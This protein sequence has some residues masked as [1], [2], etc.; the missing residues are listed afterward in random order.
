MKNNVAVLLS[1]YNGSKYIVELLESLSKQLFKD[2]DLIIRDDGSSDSTLNAILD[3][4][5]NNQLNIHIVDS[6]G[7]AGAA[8][9][10]IK[11]L[12]YANDCQQYSYFLFCD[13]DDIWHQDKIEVLVN[14]IK[15]EE[16]NNPDLPILVHS[17][18]SVVNDNGEKIFPSFWKFQHI[19]PDRNTT[20]RLLIQNT[21][22]GCTAAINR[23]L[24]NQIKVDVECMIVHDWWIALV[25]SAIG[26]I[27]P[28]H[29]QL[30]DYRQHEQNVIGARQYGIVSVLSELYKQPQRLFIRLYRLIKNI[31]YQLSALLYVAILKVLSIVL[32]GYYSILKNK[33]KSMAGINEVNIHLKDDSNNGNEVSMN[34]H[35]KQAKQL[36]LFYGDIANKESK[37]ALIDFSS[38]NQKKYFARKIIILRGKFLPN[39]FYRA[40]RLFISV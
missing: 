37:R 9:S 6:E 23:A 21:V 15:A 32:G 27:V 38:I 3:Y 12:D 26:K 24:S 33:V 31:V 40:L 14:T 4:Q 1:T 29:Q 13:Q 22:T 7:N 18:L 17:D 10:F 2:F 39:G 5:K 28:I 35:V 20:S 19:D 30:I 25:A 36:L 11:L 16:L 8:N 34:D